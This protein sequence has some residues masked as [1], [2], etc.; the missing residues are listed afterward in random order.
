MNGE[1]GILLTELHDGCLNNPALRLRILHA[2]YDF[3]SHRVEQV[4]GFEDYEAVVLWS[5]ASSGAMGED[6]GCS[7][8]CSSDSGCGGYSCCDYGNVIGC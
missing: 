8:D 2:P 5:G 4:S 7:S 6:P 3:L 1:M